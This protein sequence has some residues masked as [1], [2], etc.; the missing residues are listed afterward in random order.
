[1]SLLSTNRYVEV[2]KIEK[3]TKYVDVPTQETVEKII[4]IP[5]PGPAEVVE[6]IE[7]YPVVKEVTKYVEVPRIE[8]IF[9]YVDH[10]VS[11]SGNH[12]NGG[13]PNASGR[14]KKSTRKTRKAGGNSTNPEV[15]DL[16]TEESEG[17]ESSDQ[18]DA[19]GLNTSGSSSNAGRETSDPGA[20]D[21]SALQLSTLSE[22]SQKNRLSK[23]VKRIKKY[24]EVPRVEKVQKYHDIPVSVTREEI[25]EVPGPLQIV[26]KYVEVIQVKKIPKYVHVPK[27]VYID[28]VVDCPKITTLDR[29]VEIPKVERI[30]H[31]E[32]TVYEQ[33]DLG[34]VQ[35][36]DPEGA[37][38]HEK[39]VEQGDDLMATTI[40]QNEEYPHGKFEGSTKQSSGSGGTGDNTPKHLH[41]DI[42]RTSDLS[43][44]QPSAN[45][46]TQLQT[47]NKAE[48]MLNTFR[49]TIAATSMKVA[50]S[51]QKNTQSTAQLLPQQS[52]ATGVAIQ[53][54][55]AF[56]AEELGADLAQNIQWSESDS[57][58]MKLSPNDSQFVNHSSELENSV[59]GEKTNRNTKTVDTRPSMFQ[60]GTRMTQAGS[61]YLQVP[62]VSGVQLPGLNPKF[63]ATNNLTQQL[64]TP[65]QRQ[66]SPNPL[67]DRR[68]LFESGPSAR[69]FP[70]SMPLLSPRDTPGVSPIPSIMGHSPRPSS[71]G[72]FSGNSPIE[73][74]IG[75]SPPISSPSM[76]MTPPASSPQSQKSSPMGI[77]NKL[78]GL[79]P[80]GN[81]FSPQPTPRLTA[82]QA[83]PQP[84][85]PGGMNLFNSR[86]QSNSRLPTDISMDRAT[87]PYT[88][89][90]V[91]FA[92]EDADVNNTASNYQRH[93]TPI[94][95]NSRNITPPTRMT[96]S[97]TKAP[98][99]RVFGTT[100]NDSALD[101]KMSQ[102]SPGKFEF[103]AN[104]T[105]TSILRNSVGSTSS[106]QDWVQFGN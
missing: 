28:K 7:E 94:G 6:I 57:Q 73:M 68:S 77:Q 65:R 67:S 89:D 48:Q 25:I 51:F 44:N 79:M 81:L 97:N 42:N 17:D 45:Q 16:V 72:I 4:E 105:N 47:E 32:E 80:M 99:S 41:T 96:A 59:S 34:T 84:L 12:G 23:N 21:E 18:A 20:T 74:P 90:L 35:I 58:L 50:E 52:R 22:G 14:Q 36:R 64:F 91:R 61:K 39:R 46:A 38:Q 69:N 9:K 37:V 26:D 1:M 53:A 102:N 54:D 88:S 43:N 70:K 15:T 29:V 82:P 24:V 49:E 104:I 11:D 66:T 95:S 8:K 5:G 33:I 19:A 92:A 78:S 76:S 30:D 83:L 55:E 98:V 103:S 75:M 2:P 86:Q 31:E 3:I 62:G 93:V 85:A 27:I 100:T 106:R 56:V 87:I 101:S 40:I 13:I 60:T 71:Q 10:F 63:S